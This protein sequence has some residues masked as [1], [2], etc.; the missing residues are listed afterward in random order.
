MS[1]HPTD[2]LAGVEGEVKWFDAKKGFGFIIGPDEQDVMVHYSVINGPGYRS[3]RDG[4]TVEYDAKLTDKG[5]KATRVV[6]LGSVETPDRRA[7]PR[8]PRQ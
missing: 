8:T 5:W 3:L 7:A 1:E 4:M 6:R 2:T